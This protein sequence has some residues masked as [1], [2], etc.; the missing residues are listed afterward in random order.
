M[1]YGEI[2]QEYTVNFTDRE[3]SLSVLG[4]KEVGQHIKM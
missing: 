2:E 1:P 3:L 4:F